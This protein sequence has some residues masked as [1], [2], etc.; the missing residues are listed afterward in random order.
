MKIEKSQKKLLRIWAA[1]HKSPFK[2]EK[3][4]GIQAVSKTE[5]DIFIYESLENSEWAPFVGGITA[6]EIV[7]SIKDAEKKF[8]I[9]NLHVNSQGG[10]VHEGN[11]IITAL[12]KS[13][14]EIHIWVDG[15]AAS[16]MSLV[17]LALP[18]ERV[19]IAKNAQIVIHS[20]KISTQG[21]PEEVTNEVKAATKVRDAMIDLYI[22]RLDEDEK[23]IRG[24]LEDGKDHYFSAPEAIAMG[25]G[26][27]AENYLDVKAS[28]KKIS[29][30]ALLQ[31]YKIAAKLKFNTM[32]IKMILVDTTDDEKI[33]IVREE[34]EPT[35]GDEVMLVA[36]DETETPYPDGET[37]IAGGDYDGWVLTIVDGAIES[38]DNT[39]AKADN[40]DSID[41]EAMLKM[42]KKNLKVTSVKDGVYTVKGGEHD[43]CK[44]TVKKGAVIKAEMPEE[45]EEEEEEVVSRK[46]KGKKKTL[47]NASLEKKFSALEKSNKEM[48]AELET[49]KKNPSANH[50]VIIKEGDLLNEKGEK[51]DR[52]SWEAK[53]N[54][55]PKF[56]RKKTE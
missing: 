23:T 52:S 8:D 1:V 46:A 24:W 32:K 25:F 45:E 36:E 7:S 47:P 54:N 38:I 37:T 51:I 4:F 56:P 18:K 49:L 29:V 31:K 17:P 3:L 5:C 16:M 30:N 40:T 19:H 14:K 35:V 27:E 55:L 20:L 6:L 10:D 50:T 33:R 2:G 41:M 44:L 9:I 39:D 43:G 12:E 53:T 42:L 15:M 22:E 48:R 26:V 28:V 34:G 21:T 13:K 11:T